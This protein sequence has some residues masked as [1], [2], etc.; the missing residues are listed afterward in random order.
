MG[1]LSASNYDQFLFVLNGVAVVLSQDL[2]FLKSFEVFFLEVRSIFFYC[3]S[4][5]KVTKYLYMNKGNLVTV[6]VIIAKFP[7]PI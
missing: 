3:R 2:S 7:S 4:I 5:Q 6:V 1:N